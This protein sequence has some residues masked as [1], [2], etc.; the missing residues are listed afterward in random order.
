MRGNGRETDGHGGTG[1]RSKRSMCGL[2]STTGGRTQHTTEGQRPKGHTGACLCGSDRA[3]ADG[4]AILRPR[5]AAVRRGS[6]QSDGVTACGGCVCGT[7]PCPVRQ[8]GGQRDKVGRAATSLLAL[9]ATVRR[10]LLRVCSRGVGWAVEQAA[11]VVCEHGRQRFGGNRFGRRRGRPAAQR[12]PP[13]PHWA[14]PVSCDSDCS[15]LSTV[16]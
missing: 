5:A 10:L 7:V 11:A 16:L 15:R 6:F 8:R 1:G 2:I 13:T 4:G 3:C 12:R 14:A 9:L